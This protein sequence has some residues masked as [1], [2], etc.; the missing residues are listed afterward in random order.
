MSLEFFQA[1]VKRQFAKNR[2]QFDYQ[3][4]FARQKSS[5]ATSSTRCGVAVER[6]TKSLANFSVQ[7]VR[8][9]AARSG[10]QIDDVE[11]LAQR[12][13][14]NQAAGVGR[15]DVGFAGNAGSNDGVFGRNRC[16]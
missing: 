4:V 15:N 6:E 9:E 5:N 11:N 12:A 7:A 10:A 8:E 2:L 13:R 1:I 16:W 14:I 3:Q